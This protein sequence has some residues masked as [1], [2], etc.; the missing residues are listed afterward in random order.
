MSLVLRSTLR[1][2][3]VARQQMQVRSLHI[4]NKVDQ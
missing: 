4:E 2:G 1:A 3:R